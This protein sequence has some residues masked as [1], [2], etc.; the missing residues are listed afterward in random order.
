MLSMFR[1]AWFIARH[2]LLHALRER[3]TILWTFVMPILFFYFIG[4]ITS[5]MGG[6]AGGRDRLAMKIPDDTGFLGDEI[7]RRLES[8]GFD[9]APSKSDE[10]FAAS[11]RRLSI[12]SDFT[13]NVLAGK[14]QVLRFSRKAADQSGQYDE[15]RVARAVYTLL[16]D[17]VVLV[18]LDAAPGEESFQRLREMPRPLRLDV[19]SAGARKEIPTGFAQAIPGTMV[20]FTLIVLLTSGTVSVITERRLGVLRRLASTPISRASIVGG[21]WACRLLLSII[22]IGFAMIAGSVLFGMNWGDSLPMVVLVLLGWGGLCASLALLLGSLVSSEGQ[23]VAIG[24]LSGNALGALGGCW[25]PIEIAPV[26]MQSLAI[27]L[28]SGWAMD[29]MHR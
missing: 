4:T 25:W 11:P 29:A 13:K 5:G 7:T 22:Q 8:A 2:D 20:M 21:K 16:A 14:K 10:E 24:V 3:E 19:E 1:D 26:W 18:S 27:C 9:V 12:P 28:P 6:S 17:L 23:A 15:V